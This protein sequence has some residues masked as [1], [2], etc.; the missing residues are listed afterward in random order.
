MSFLES[1]HQDA[2]ND[3]HCWHFWRNFIFGLFQAKAKILDQKNDEICFSSYKPLMHIVGTVLIR[4]FQKCP[5]I[6]FLINLQAQNE[7]KCIKNGPFLL[8]LG[9]IFWEGQAV[10]IFLKCVLRSWDIWESIPIHH[11]FIIIS[12]GNIA[13]LISKIIEK[14]HTVFYTANL[15][16]LNMIK[17]I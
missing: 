14:L 16:E 11:F 6:L 9:A 4:R 5:K 12:R 2:S 7:P 13:F 8:I 3:V 17:I 10:A 1:S 15:R